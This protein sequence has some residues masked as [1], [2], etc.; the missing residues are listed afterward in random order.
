MVQQHQPTA[1]QQSNYNNYSQAYIAQQT[2]RLPMHSPA[3]HSAVQVP[4]VHATQG[5]HVQQTP[6]HGHHQHVSQPQSNSA[7]MGTRNE[8][9]PVATIERK[10]ER[11]ILNI[12]DPNTG[13][14]HSFIHH[15][16]LLF[17]KLMQFHFHFRCSRY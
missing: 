2:A 14:I 5:Q 11:K 17:L 12:V 13:I 16:V 9:V 15:S 1:Q 10:R 3:V 7:Q 6:Q 8:S 4:T